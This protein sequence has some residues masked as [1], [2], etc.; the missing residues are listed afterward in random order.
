LSA[1]HPNIIFV[2]SLKMLLCYRSFRMACVVSSDTVC[3]QRCFFF[4]FSLFSHQNSR[5]SCEI[6]V[7]SYD[8]MGFL[9]W[10]LFLLSLIF[11]LDLDHEFNR[12]IQVD[13]GLFL[14]DIFFSISSLNIEF[15]WKSSFINYFDL[16]SIYLFKS[17]DSSCNFNM[18]TWV[19]SNYLF[20][21]LFF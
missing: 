8:F 13:S 9:L 16:L 21:C 6:S 11:V 19:N 10:S 15:N 20:F 2:M 5:W 3:C 14:I 7:L 4:S 12:L 1:R 18:L 17:H